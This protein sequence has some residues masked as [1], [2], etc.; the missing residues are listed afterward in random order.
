[1]IKDEEI[2]GKL[3]KKAEVFNKHFRNKDF[4]QAKFTREAAGMV[5]VFTEMPETDRIELFGLRNKDNQI[6]GLFDTEKCIRA[7]FECIKARKDLQGIGKKEMEEII[8][9]WS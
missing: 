7:G 3:R 6:E 8:K 4:L 9:K 2:A 5:A 1:M